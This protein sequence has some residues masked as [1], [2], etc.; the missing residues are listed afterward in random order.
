METRDTDDPAELLHLGDP[1]QPLNDWA[2]RAMRNGRSRADV[3]GQLRELATTN[4]GRAI[5]SLLLT[6]ADEVEEY[7]AV[8]HRAALDLARNA[9]PQH[10]PYGV[11]TSDPWAAGLSLFFFYGTPEE[12]TAALLDHHAFADTADADHEPQ[13]AWA[14]TR[15]RLEQALARD[16]DAESLNHLTKDA[17][18][19]EWIGTFEDLC[20][21]TDEYAAELRNE[22]R[23]LDSDECEFDDSPITPDERGAFAEF[24]LEHGC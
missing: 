18:G 5:A 15:G 14:E 23:E 20:S 1:T 13:Q 22:F 19:V 3:A 21:A 8:G 11:R 16:D 2:N 17:F 24:V 4:D 6:M 7:G 9:D 10:A 12:R